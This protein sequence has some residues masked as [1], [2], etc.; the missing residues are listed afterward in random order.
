M[1][2]ENHFQVIIVGGGHAGCEAALAAARLGTRTL[3]IVQDLNHVA[4]MPC[5]PS[6]GGPAKGHLVREISALGGTQARAADA[7]A[8]MMRW[9][10]TSKGPAVR[11]L[12]SQND[13][14]E[15][16]DWYLRELLHCPNLTVFQDTV[17]HLLVDDGA[18]TG[19]STRFEQ[20]FYA[21]R[22]ILT[23]GTH[24]GGR[25]HVGLINFSSGPMG[26]MAADELGKDLRQLGI[27]IMRLKTGTT[28]RVHR[29]SIDWTRVGTQ[30]GERSPVCFDIWGTPKIYRD[31]TCGITRTNAETHRIIRENLDRSP[32]VQGNIHGIGPRYCPSIESK[33]IAFPEKDSHPIFLEPVDRLGVEIY[34]QNFSTSLPIDV[35]VQMTQTLP[36]FEHA[37]I[38]RPGYAIEYDAVDPLQL[39]PW[40]EMKAIPG[41]FCA[42][43]INGTSGYEEAAAQGLLAGINAVLTLRGQP[44]VVLGRHEAYLGVLVDDLVTKGTTE[45]YRMLTSRCE[46]R[47]LLRHDNADRRLAPLGYRLGLLNEDQWR[48][49]NERWLAVDHEVARLGSARYSPVQVNVLLSKL[50]GSPVDHGVSAIDLLRRPEVSYSDLKDLLPPPLLEGEM[51]GQT[52]IIVKYQGYVDRQNRAVEKLLR[53]EDV[54]IPAN[55][56]YSSLK[57][58]LTESLEKLKKVHPTTLGQASRISGVTPIDVQTLAV[59]IQ[60]HGN[61]VQPSISDSVQGPAKDKK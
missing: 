5:N 39:N 23:T 26:Q 28:P 30:E 47:L 36:G 52:E 59:M 31:V 6:I 22:V 20:R 40:L 45:P 29:D 48:V 10:N 43:Q 56:D 50:G 58:L 46:H 57:G 8:M 38:L 19:V 33:V 14:H 16:H 9:L 4:Y 21:P 53:M 1:N 35:Q 17:V 11:A 51:A 13:L 2:K 25:V 55:F 7:S 32:I 12:R 49:L 60:A 18:V 42:G 24:L 15:Y 44:P 41:L 54:K 61:R 27:A 3:M 37:K 34:I